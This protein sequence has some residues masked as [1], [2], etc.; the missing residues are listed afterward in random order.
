MTHGLTPSQDLETFQRWAIAVDDQLREAVEAVL[1][2]EDP[3]AEPLADREAT[4]SSNRSNGELATEV[5]K[6]IEQFKENPERPAWF[7]PA[8]QMV[9][10]VSTW[11]EFLMDYVE[12]V[13]RDGKQPTDRQIDLIV[14]KIDPAIEHFGRFL[15]AVKAAGHLSN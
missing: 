10:V 2:L 1:A 12:E 5:L 9:L 3:E 4:L 11:T 14:E 13:T 8:W 15:E 7:T 6:D